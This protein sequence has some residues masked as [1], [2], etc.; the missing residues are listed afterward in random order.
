MASRFPARNVLKESPEVRTKFLWHSRRTATCNKDQLDWA[1]EG[2]AWKVVK[3][4]ATS[5]PLITNRP[6]QLGGE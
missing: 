1:S 5:L 4:V 3:G 2:R 6:R